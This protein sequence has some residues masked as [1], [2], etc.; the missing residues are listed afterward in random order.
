M[1]RFAFAIKR[2]RCNAAT[3]HDESHVLTSP[4]AAFPI[5]D[6]R[7]RTY[8]HA[9]QCSAHRRF[10]AGSFAALAQLVEQRI[11]NA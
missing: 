11:R 1:I 10:R 4:C 7:V 6:T 5:D 9:T 3:P 2:G 8:L